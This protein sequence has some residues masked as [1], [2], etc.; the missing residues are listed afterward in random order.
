MYHV[1]I[2]SNIRKLLNDGYVDTVTVICEIM[3]VGPG[4]WRMNEFIAIML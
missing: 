2:M 1:L 4:A 3:N